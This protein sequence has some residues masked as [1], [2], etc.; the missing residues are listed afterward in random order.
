[1]VSPSS[2]GAALILFTPD[3]AITNILATKIYRNMKLRRPGIIPNVRGGN[4]TFATHASILSLA[5]LYAPQGNDLISLDQIAHKL[6]ESI[7][8]AGLL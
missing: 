7:H 2:S 1:M 3:V 8:S 4:R 5:S 6:T